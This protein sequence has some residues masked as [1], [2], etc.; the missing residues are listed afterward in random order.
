[1]LWERE[2]G[3]GRNG[4]SPVRITLFFDPFKASDSG[5]DFLHSTEIPNLW[6]ELTPYF[7]W[8][9]VSQISSLDIIGSRIF[10]FILV[11]FSLVVFWFLAIRVKRVFDI[12]IVLLFCLH[13]THRLQ[14]HY[15]TCISHLE[16]E[17]HL[18]PQHKQTLEY[19]IFPKLKCAVILIYTY[20]CVPR[21]AFWKLRL[22]TF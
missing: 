1:M 22:S 8:S 14:L 11:D 15:S 21:L 19:L 3:I 20:R 9:W 4:F 10:Y 7:L 17:F 13:K 6:S 5:F 16:V 12:K 2:D 18:H